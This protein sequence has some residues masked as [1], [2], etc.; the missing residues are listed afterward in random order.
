MHTH[1]HT[2]SRRRRS[3][4]AASPPRRT[5]PRRH[6]AR[7]H[8]ALLSLSHA[9]PPAGRERRALVSTE[10]TATPPC[11]ATWRR[12]RRR[13]RL[14]TS[15]V[16][17]LPSRRHASATAARRGH[18]PSRQAH[19]A[20]VAAARCSVRQSTMSARPCSEQLG[21]E[22]QSGPHCGVI[23]EGGQGVSLAC[24]ADALIQGYRAVKQA[25]GRFGGVGHRFDTTSRRRVRSGPRESILRGDGNVVAR[26][27]VPLHHARRR[28]LGGRAIALVATRGLAG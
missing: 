7:P 18:A 5:P 3:L 4:L 1:T 14:E 24:F 8:A 9:L 15:G 2:P 19:A 11:G 20:P 17:L 26:P 10:P 6:A 21:V 16:A 12:R 27:A 25:D 23:A 28:S 13:S 22:A